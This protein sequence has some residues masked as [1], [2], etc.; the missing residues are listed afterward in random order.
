MQK[1]L[2]WISV[3]LVLV[4]GGK[5]LWDSLDRGAYR[6]SAATRVQ[7]FLD[8]ISPGGDLQDSFNMWLRGGQS[9]I[10]TITQDEY[11]AYVNQMTAWLAERELG[12][13]IES[14]EVTATTLV[15]GRDGLE[16]A[17]VDVNCTIDGTP[18]VIRAVEGAPLTWAD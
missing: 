10:G 9:G 11:N 8:G 5:Y 7:G 4:V 13:R 16:P 18:V 6:N 14:Y 1:L 17:I 2:I 12:N 15:R 3:F